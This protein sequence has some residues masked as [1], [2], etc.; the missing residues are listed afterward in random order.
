MFNQTTPGWM[1]WSSLPDTAGFLDTEGNKPP[2]YCHSLYLASTCAVLCCCMWWRASFPWWYQ[3]MQKEQLPTSHSNTITHGPELWD[4]LFHHT[5]KNARKLPQPDALHTGSHRHRCG[6]PSHHTHEW[7]EQHRWFRDASKTQ[8]WRERSDSSAHPVHWETVK[9]NASSAGGVRTGN[10]SRI[11]R[12]S[13]VV[14]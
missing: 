9:K 5:N 10:Q 12:G 14:D 6:S 13:W 1:R 2:H 4:G 8:R 7:L 11:S 3:L